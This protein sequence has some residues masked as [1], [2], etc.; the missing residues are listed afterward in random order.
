MSTYIYIKNFYLEEIQ[1]IAQEYFNE[2]YETEA[3][4][5]AEVLMK[6]SRTHYIKFSEDLAFEELFAWMDIFQQNK[7]SNERMTTIEGIISTDQI[8]YKFYYINEELFGIDSNHQSYKIEHLEDL[9]PIN[10][11]PLPFSV[12]EIPSKN[13]HSMAIIQ[14]QKPKKKKWWKFWN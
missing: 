13:L 3:L 1:P 7:P 11:T 2:N 10:N 4:L 9:V 8:N 12:N 14:H 5:C 6:N